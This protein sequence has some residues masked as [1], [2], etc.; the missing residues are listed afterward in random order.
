M[1]NT[2]SEKN[3]GDRVTTFAGTLYSNTKSHYGY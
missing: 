2:K 1:K 3:L